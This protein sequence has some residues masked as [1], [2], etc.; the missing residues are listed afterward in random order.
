MVTSFQLQIRQS[1]PFASPLINLK[2]W[3]SGAITYEQTCLDGFENTTGDAGAKMKLVL[4]TAQ[5]LTKNGL[6]MVV[7]LSKSLTKSDSTIVFLFHVTNAIG[8]I[9]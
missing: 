1:R 7:E 4:K 8:Q 9:L 5:E 3:L 2:V 6:A